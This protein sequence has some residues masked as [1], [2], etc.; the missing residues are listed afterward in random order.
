MVVQPESRLNWDPGLHDRRVIFGDEMHGGAYSR[1]VANCLTMPRLDIP[2][3]RHAVV[4]GIRDNTPV[5]AF[6]H[7]LKLLASLEQPSINHPVP[8]SCSIPVHF[9]YSV[10]RVSLAHAETSCFSGTAYVARR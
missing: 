2:I 9:H 1:R 6:I 7:S 4:S 5:L 8:C 3:T 10:G